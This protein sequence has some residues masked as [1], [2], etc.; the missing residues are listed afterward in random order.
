[1][2]GISGKERKPAIEI[3]SA[4]PDDSEGISEVMYE[5]WLATYPNEEAGI[6]V[7]DIEDSYK[8]RRSPERMQKSRARLE[9]MP[10][11]ERRFVAKIDGRVVGVTRVIKNE[12]FNKLQTLYVLPELQGQG[13]G[14]SLWEAARSFFDPKKDVFL[15]VA[16]YNEKAIA[17]Y[18]NLG[19]E[20]TG[21]RL[22]DERFRMKS[23]NIV[24]E[25]EMRL[26]VQTD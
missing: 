4:T 11:N 20:D 16:T 24:P 23:G 5:A 17:F 6:T 1:M 18:K 26:R 9:N 25:M 13:V 10:E 14:T 3:S 22:S 15:E 7:D 21:K 19:F 8:D 12:D 2:E